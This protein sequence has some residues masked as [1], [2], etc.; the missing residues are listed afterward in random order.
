[1]RYFKDYERFHPTP[2]DTRRDTT[3]LEAFAHRSPPGA[4]SMWQD[5]L[6]PPVGGSGQ[7]FL[8]FG[9]HIGPSGALRKRVS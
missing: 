1:M 5:D 3:S 8:R 2:P 4:A 6:G 7:Q 9:K